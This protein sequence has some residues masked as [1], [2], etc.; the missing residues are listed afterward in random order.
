MRIL[1][2]PIEYYDKVLLRRI[3]NRLGCTAKVDI[4]TE[5]ATRAK[6]ARLSVEVDLSKPLIAKFRMRRRIWR[7]EY[8]GI[9]LVCFRCG[10]Y[11]HKE[12]IYPNNTEEGIKKEKAREE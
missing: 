4:A 9:H 2:L 1:N 7:L 12:E 5:E 10:K 11:G 8:E 3:G 6:Y